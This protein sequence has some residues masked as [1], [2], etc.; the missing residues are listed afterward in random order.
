MCLNII[1]NT[2]IIQYIHESIDKFLDY[3]EE[4][5]YL[6][7]YEADLRSILYMTLF[8]YRKIFRQP[9]YDGEQTETKTNILH[10]EYKYKK[11]GFYDIVVLDPNKFHKDYL[12]RKKPILVGFEL[13]LC[14]N[15]NLKRAYE[16]MENDCYAFDNQKNDKSAE[17]GFVILV[18][19]VQEEHEERDI[20]KLE[21][22]LKSLKN[23]RNLE[24]V[25]FYYIEMPDNNSDLWISQV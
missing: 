6:L 13:K 16:L 3:V 15:S 4:N 19:I 25:S 1:K 11:G 24:K 18:N 8:K 2:K 10:T 9:I 5:P 22:K 12:L 17:Y 7:L 23:K 21:Q 20:N 14:E